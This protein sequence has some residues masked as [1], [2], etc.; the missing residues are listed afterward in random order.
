[1]PG[2]GA[3]PLAVSNCKRQSQRTPASD[4]IAELEPQYVAEHITERYTRHVT[5]HVSQ[6]VT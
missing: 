2:T 5:E 3:Q 6:C 4:P 1:M